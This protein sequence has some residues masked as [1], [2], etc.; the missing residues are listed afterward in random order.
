VSWLII[1]GFSAQTLSVLAA[2][3]ADPRLAAE[4]G[5]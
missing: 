2:L 4:G 5:A 1:R 3:E